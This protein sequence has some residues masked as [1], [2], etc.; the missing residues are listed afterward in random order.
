[1]ANE[2]YQDIHEDYSQLTQLTVPLEHAAAAFATKDESGRVPIVVVPERPFRLKIEI[3]GL[4]L[5]LLIAGTA[6]GAYLGSNLLIGISI[7]FGLLMVVLGVYRSYYLRIPEGV[8]ALLAKGGRYSA[9]IG[10]GPQVLPP[11]IAIT[12]LIT[13]REI[14]FEVPVIQAPTKDNVRADFN[15]LITFVISE[16]YRFVYNIST[17]DF[18]LVFQAICQDTIRSMIRETNSEQVNDLVLQDH[19]KL[20]EDLNNEMEPYGV[21]IMRINIISAQPPADFMLSQE[22]QKLAELQQAEQAERQALAMRRQTDEDALARQRVIAQVEREREE[23]QLEVQRAET[24]ARVVELEARAEALRLA[25]LE[26]RLRHYPEAMQWEWAGTQLEAIRALA[27]NSRV[28]IQVGDA[29]MLVRSLIMRDMGQETS[30]S[31]IEGIDPGTAA[32]PNE[33][34]TAT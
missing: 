32:A 18:D 5:I 26:E 13:R 25:E 34:D 27:T 16:P 8:Q 3:I 30:S 4:G 14:P 6:G 12:H 31:V 19:T 23:L 17:D 7:L 20:R 29:D 2:Q 21:S 10:S 9:T 24:Q 28:V 15:T 1:M 33:E 22:A 11:W